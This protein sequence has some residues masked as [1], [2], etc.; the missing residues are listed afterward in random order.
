MQVKTTMRCRFTP[1]TM[2]IIKMSKTTDADKA[3]DKR[4]HLYTV[5][6]K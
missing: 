4:E 1:D 5:R 2:A 3:A 6:G